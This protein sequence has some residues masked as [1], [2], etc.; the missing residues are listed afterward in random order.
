MAINSKPETLSELGKALDALEARLLALKDWA[1]WKGQ[2]YEVL[3]LRQGISGNPDEDRVVNWRQRTEAVTLAQDGKFVIMVQALN[4]FT[5]QP[6]TSGPA[7]NYKFQ[8]DIMHRPVLAKSLDGQF[9]A[10]CVIRWVHDQP[11]IE[12]K[13]CTS[14]LKVKSG[15]GGM[16]TDGKFFIT[17]LTLDWE[18]ILKPADQ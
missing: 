1:D 16:D 9:A 6:D 13:S 3:T 18:S 7:C 14:K 17:K 15:K 5:T 11:L 8:I 4:D 12:R 2:P 10:E